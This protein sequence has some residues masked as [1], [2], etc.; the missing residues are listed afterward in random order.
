MGVVLLGL[1]RGCPR[2]SGEITRGT[3]GAD[4]RNC[5]GLGH[6]EPLARQLI[7]SDLPDA[8]GLAQSQPARFHDFLMA[9]TV[10]SHTA[11]LRV[12]SSRYL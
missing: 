6:Q 4:S 1:N 5:L 11:S 2:C 7:E 9:K 3:L 12:I 8:K 10:Y